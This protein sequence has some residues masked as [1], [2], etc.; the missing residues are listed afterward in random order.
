MNVDPVIDEFVAHVDP[1]GEIFR[2]VGSTPW[3]EPLE[4][5]LP[6]RFP[7]SFR[8]LITR[9]TFPAFDAC[10]LSFFSNTGGDSPE[11][12]GVAIFK[13][14]AVAGATLGVGFIQFA[15][16]ESG[17]YDPVCFDARR[18][19]SNREY[20]VVRLDHEDILCRGGVRG[21]RVVAGSFYHLA[22]EIAGRA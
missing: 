21:L 9:Y 22:A 18:A 6:R 2:R 12:L 1:P 11:E 14:A 5:K 8:S 13:D 17:S 10:G 19:A 4:S 7:V 16:P 15:R 3:V 20:P